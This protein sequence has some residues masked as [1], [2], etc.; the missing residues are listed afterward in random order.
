MNKIIISHFE[1]PRKNSLLSYN[2]L[3]M[4]LSGVSLTFL[5]ADKYYDNIEFVGDEEAWN[6]ISKL[7][8]PWSNIK[9]LQPDVDYNKKHL[10]NFWNYGK[11]IAMKLSTPPFIH[12]DTDVFLL[13]NCLPEFSDFLFQNAEDNSF[14]KKHINKIYSNS[15]IT[16]ILPKY[17]FYNNEKYV[18]YNCG[19]V[20]IG[21]ERLRDEWLEPIFKFIDLLDVKY[22]ENNDNLINWPTFIEQYSV[23]CFAKQNNYNVQL[24]GNDYFY[25]ENKAEAIGYVHLLGPSKRQKYIEE[26]LLNRLQKDFPHQSNLISKII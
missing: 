2:T 25:L 19:I 5:T 12:I 17:M 18:A 16:N 10:D 9:I 7:E 15:D 1:G 21:N 6:I 26:K 23:C 20:G 3:K 24:L 13:K 22:I 8:L 4:F 14:Y 11:L